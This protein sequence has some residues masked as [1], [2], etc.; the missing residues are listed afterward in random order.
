GSADRYYRSTTSGLFANDNYKLRSNLTLTGGLR[1]DID[2]PLSEKYGRLTAFDPSK[3]SYVQ[4][5]V[6][7]VPA[8]PALT[9]YDN[10]Y[11]DGSCDSGTDVITNSGLEIAG[12]NK[13]GGTP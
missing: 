6:N 12:N 5:K 1:W 11:Y 2:G 7:G 9:E 13:T 10:G 4:C 8:D 3:Y